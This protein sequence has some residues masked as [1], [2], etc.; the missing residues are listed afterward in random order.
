[1]M[2]FTDAVILHNLADFYNRYPSKVNYMGHIILK[3]EKIERCEIGKTDR[4]PP[5][6]SLD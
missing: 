6:L 4:E 2:D 1:M 5:S 3:N